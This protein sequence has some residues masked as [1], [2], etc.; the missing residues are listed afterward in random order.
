MSDTK[1]VMTIEEKLDLTKFTSDHNHAHITIDTVI[2]KTKCTTHD[3]VY[4]CPADCY[5]FT[6]GEDA[7]EPVSFDYIACLEC[8]TCRIVCPHGSVDWHYPK[9]G[10]GVEFKQS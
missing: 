9:G 1:K 6:E 3:C 7:E 10:F 2:C 4:C 5:K 8:G